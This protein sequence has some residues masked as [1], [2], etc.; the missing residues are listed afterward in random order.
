[1]FLKDSE[2]YNARYFV[3]SLL[4]LLLLYINSTKLSLSA[5]QIA[6]SEI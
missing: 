5:N 3:D 2:N 4:L 6:A 1:M